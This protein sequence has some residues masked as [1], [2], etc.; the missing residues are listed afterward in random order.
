MQSLFSFV[1]VF[2]PPR[3]EPLCERSKSNHLQVSSGRTALLRLYWE[4]W[5]KIGYF[6]VKGVS[7]PVAVSVLT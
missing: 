7:I 6:N 2:L 1:L 5:G 3:T 4:T